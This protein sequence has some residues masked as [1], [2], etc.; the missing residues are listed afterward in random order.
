[1]DEFRDINEK[2][3]V[4]EEIKIEEMG[5]K[6]ENETKF[7]KEEIKI[8][9]MGPKDENETEFIKEEIKVEEVEIKDENKEFIKEEPKTEE[10]KNENIIEEVVEEK[11]NYY[12]QIIKPQK[13]KK[14]RFKKLTALMTA[15]GI[16]L[17]GLSV[18]LGIG[19]AGPVN[20]LFLQPALKSASNK[21]FNNEVSE[22]NIEEEKE[23]SFED[24]ENNN[25]NVEEV[26]KKEQ[27]H[28]SS[29]NSTSQITIP[30][31]NKTIGPSVV[32]IKNI[33]TV[34]DFWYGQSQQEGTGSGI[35]F[36]VTSEDVKIVTNYHVVEN[37]QSLVVTF[38]GEYSVPA[39]IVGVD[40][41]TDL[42]VIK[43]DQSDIP[44]EIKGKIV[45]APFGDS[46]EIEVGELAVAIGNPLGE[47]Y[48]NTVTA[49]II[50]AVN[51]TIQLT[52]KEMTLIQTDAAINPGN[53]GGALVGSKGTVIGINTIKLVDTSVEGMGFAI[54]I[55]VAKPI[56]EELVNK[57]SVSRPYLGIVGQDISENI[58]ELYE[59]PVGVLVREVQPGSAAYIGGLKAGDI[60]IEFDGEKITSMEQLAEI[61]S[62]HE[63]GDKVTVKFVRDGAWKKTITVILQDKSELTQW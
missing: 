29:T 55:N 13:N 26:V 56:I 15:L 2:E 1:M 47:A 63:V 22:E 14:R 34:N 50:S 37:S 58:A 20:E 23:F 21:F 4:K 44:N 49:G 9:E 30:M 18:G 51:R 25:N 19:L 60:I 33:Y 57:G 42:A 52:D 17:G 43:V 62:N 12:T 38:L 8:E 36:H 45:A 11:N 5:P 53:S 41:Q 32:S 10:I 59:V 6:D 16:I 31:I 40:S 39:S 28:T 27:L 61:I 3:D 46:D 54:P 35:I 48:S 7:I 24:I